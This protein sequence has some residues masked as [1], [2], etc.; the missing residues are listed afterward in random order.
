LLDKIMREIENADGPITVKELA[1]KVGVAE[2]ALPGM[3][4]FL[5]KKGRLSLVLAGEWE[6]CQVASCE[7]CAMRGWCTEDGKEGAI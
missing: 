4:E 2:S 3:L 1:R 5:Q 6:Q 7:A